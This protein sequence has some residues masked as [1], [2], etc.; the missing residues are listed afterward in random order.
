[1]NGLCPLVL[2]SCLLLALLVPGPSDSYSLRVAAFNIQVFGTTKANKPEVLNVLKEILS[3]YD[4]VLVQEIR[5]SSNKAIYKLLNELNKISVETY[6]IVLSTRLG[7]TTSK[8]QYAFI[9]KPD[10]VRLK[11]TYQWPD[12][13]D[14]FER[15]PFI[16]HFAPT[17]PKYDVGGFAF[18]GVH[19]KPDKAPEEI[20]RLTSVYES[21]S[22]MWGLQDM[23]IGG[24]LNAD[25]SYVSRRDWQN[26][27]LRHDPRFT[28]TLG[29]GIDT[30]ITGSNCAYD[31]LIIAGKNLLHD[32][33]P[34]SAKAYKFNEDLRLP[35]SLA[36][37]V[38]DHYPVEILLS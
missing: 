5:D 30:T 35:L 38:S 1:M 23:L 15:E 10:L 18:M 34:G 24:D 19:I 16:A 3:R 29:D 25:C 11:E 4:I 9:Y 14:Q 6:D 13:G 37:N 8:E 20:N 26:I 22:A 21:V 7:R 17:S 28:W 27:T 31:R 36:L 32:Y 12:V 33:V 2:L